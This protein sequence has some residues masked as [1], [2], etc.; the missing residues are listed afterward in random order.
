VLRGGDQAARI[1]AEER[2]RQAHLLDRLRQAATSQRQEAERLAHRLAATEE[3]V[4]RLAFEVHPPFEE[5]A[6]RLFRLDDGRRAAEQ[7]PTSR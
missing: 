6:A 5:A 1:L 2:E 4:R 3:E 7:S